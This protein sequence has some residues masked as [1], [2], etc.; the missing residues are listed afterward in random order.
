MMRR[1]LDG[2][3]DAAAWLAALC[4]VGLLGM[5][6]L[7]IVSR[8]LSVSRARH[9]RLRR[10]PDGRGRF[11]GAGAHLEAQ[12]AHPRHAAGPCPERWRASCARALVAVRPPPSCPGRWAWFASAGWCGSRWKFN[13]ISTGNDATPLWIPQLA[14]RDRQLVL[15]VAFV[16]ELVLEV[17]GRRAP[18]SGTER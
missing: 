17:R 12:R 3:Y 10:L 4:M 2:L 5:V 9:R 8:Q 14:W 13:D 6:L 7:S 16:D 15:L 1:F 18:A 11:P